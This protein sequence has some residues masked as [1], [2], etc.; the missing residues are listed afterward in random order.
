[1]MSKGVFFPLRKDTFCVQRLGRN[2]R[3]RVNHDTALRNTNDC[4]LRSKGGSRFGAHTSLAWTRKGCICLLAG[5][6][7]V[8]RDG[9]RGHQESLII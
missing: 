4:R 3:G 1:M 9:V 6:V 7:M 2:D 8:G 5:I